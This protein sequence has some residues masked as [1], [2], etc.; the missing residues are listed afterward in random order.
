MSCGRLSAALPFADD[1]GRSDEWLGK[2]GVRRL[3]GQDFTYWFMHRAFGW[4]VVLQL[5]WTFPCAVSR[6]DLDAVNAALGAGP[7]NRRVTRASVM[8]ARPRWGHAP[9][10]P[11]VICDTRPIANDGV[12]AWAAE[13]LDTV[14]LDP[15]HGATYRLRAVPTE[16]GGCVVSLT[17]LHLVTDGKGLVTAAAD[18]LAGRATPDTLGIDP[19]PSP[20][21]V[22][23]DT[24]DAVAGVVSA[25]TGI[26]TAA[27]ALIR[28][29]VTG[30]S[31]R[32]LPVTG[33]EPSR[34]RRPRTP[35]RD[36]SPRAQTTWAIVSVPAAEFAAVAQRHGGT[37]NTLFIA[38]ITGALRS[39]S[40]TGPGEHLKV[41][42]PVDQRGIDDDRANATAGVSVLVPGSLRAGDDLGSLR[43]DCKHAYSALTAGERAMIVHL[44][45]ALRLL[46]LSVVVAAVTSG[47]GM[48]DVMTS[49][50]GS[51]PGDVATLAGM[52]ATGMAFR[53][54]AIGVDPGGPHRFGDGL[55][56]WLLQ[57]GDTVTISVAAFDESAFADGAAL[58]SGLAAELDR[59]GVLHRIW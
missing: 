35:I 28:T 47:D 5:V 31:R 38:L 19:G 3:H 12:E 34:R 23:A 4:S 45:P 49:N 22:V 55:Q 17:A 33:A 21:T 56:A 11:D 39:A 29:A 41:G 52:Q 43:Q 32:A 14:P 10:V 46:P 2:V 8:T 6:G 20:R 16:D 40:P 57:A 53:G 9:A 24:G 44:Q 54:D 42:I 13:E 15:E 18:A 7:L 48:P 37:V 26:A 59:W 30:R 58:R 50:I 25:G 1:T 51:Y 27:G 36:R